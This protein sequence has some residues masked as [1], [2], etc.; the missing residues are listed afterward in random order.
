MAVHRKKHMSTKL[1][2]ASVM[3]AA[4]AGLPAHG[5]TI[6]PTPSDSMIIEVDGQL[7]QKTILQEA[8][9]STPNQV[10]SMDHGAANIA[11]YG[12]PLILLEGAN[13]DPG[14]TVSDIVGVIQKQGNNWLSGAVGFISNVG[15]LSEALAIFGVTVP[16]DATAADLANVAGITVMDEPSG[17]IDIGQYLSP[18]YSGTFQSDVEPVHD[19]G[20]TMAMLG[21][22]ITGVGALRRRF[23]RAS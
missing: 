3:L 23:S 16:P 7:N 21:M 8:A 22:A 17:P 9:E 13:G 5:N 1:L 11:A 18:G 10:F 19:G 4:L 6:A 20:I 15:S 12:H 2:W 14:E